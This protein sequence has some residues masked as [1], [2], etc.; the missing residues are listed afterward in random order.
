MPTTG[1]SFLDFWFHVFVTPHV[2][3]AFPPMGWLSFAIAGLLY[4]RLVLHPSATAARI[5]S[6]TFVAALLLALLFVLTRVLRFGNLSEG[7][8]PPPHTRDQGG[9]GTGRIGNQYLVSPQAFFYLTKYPPDVAFFAYTLAVNLLFLTALDLVPRRFLP[10]TTT[11][12]PTPPTGTGGGSATQRIAS[13]FLTALLSILL[14][15]GNSALFF[16]MAHQFVVFGA[17]SLLTSLFG[18]E[19]PGE[20]NPLHPG[21]PLRGI[22]SVWAFWGLWAFVMVVMYPCCR[23]YARFK[24]TKGVDSVWRFF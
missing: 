20:T 22:Q 9:E 1:T 6:G 23:W 8:L 4:A 5:R 14:T 18:R 15:F 19:I 16:Y 3:S 24:G 10:A 17:G 2:I 13:R 11:T 7:C 12:K 21:E